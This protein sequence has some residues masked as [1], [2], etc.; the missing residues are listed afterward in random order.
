MKISD[1]TDYIRQQ[2]AGHFRRPEDGKEPYAHVNNQK[3]ASRADKEKGSVYVKSEKV[4]TL[5]RKITESGFP[6]LFDSDSGWK[7]DTERIGESDKEKKLQLQY[8]KN[9]KTQDVNKQSML[10]DQW[11]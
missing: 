6:K 8:D 5:E 2:Q 11:A 3:L 4:V 9:G 7:V 1:S 10:V